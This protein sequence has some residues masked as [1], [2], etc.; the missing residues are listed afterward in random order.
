M[1]AMGKKEKVQLE[2]LDKL[3]SHRDQ[4]IMS[5]RQL[6]NLGRKIEEQV[7]VFEQD[8]SPKEAEEAQ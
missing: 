2:E 1:I 3:L 8:V 6:V 4:M 5:W 7:A